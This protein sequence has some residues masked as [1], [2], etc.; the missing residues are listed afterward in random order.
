MSSIIANLFGPIFVKDMAELSRH[1]RT[2]LYRCL[3]GTL[4]LVSLGVVYQ[5]FHRY[6]HQRPGEVFPLA[7]MAEQFFHTYLW[8]QYVAVLLL[9]PLLVPGAVAGEHEKGTLDLLLTTQLRN[10]D[11]YFGKL[12][13][14]V[15][16]L[17][18][19]ILSGIP[20]VAFTILFGGVDLQVFWNAMLGTLVALVWV[21]AN[22]MFC[23]IVAKDALTALVLSFGM[24]SWVWGIPLIIMLTTS[25]LLYCQPSDPAGGGM[26]RTLYY[27]H[28]ELVI[29]SLSPF[30]PFVVGISADLGNKFQRL[31]GN[32][33]LYWMMISPLAWSA[34]VLAASLRVLRHDRTIIK[35]K[36]PGSLAVAKRNLLEQVWSGLWFV[37]VFR[38]LMRWLGT[39]PPDR[40]LWF[41]ITNPL[42][43]RSRRVLVHDRMGGVIIMQLQCWILSIAVFVA[44]FIF[45]VG[46]FKPQEYAW[47][48]DISIWGLLFFISI[49]L[50][51]IGNVL[52]RYRGLLDQLLVTP[53][54]PGELVKGALLTSWQHW[55]LT[56]LLLIVVVVL[57]VAMGY[58]LIWEAI[59]MVVIGFLSLAV[60][61]LEAVAC[62]L[63]AR[64]VVSGLLSGFA[65]P[66]TLWV[67]LPMLIR[68]W[69]VNFW[70]ILLVLGA[71]LP[72]SWALMRWRKNSFTIPFYLGS[73]HLVFVLFASVLMLLRFDGVPFS[74][75]SMIEGGRLFTY[76]IFQ[77]H[78]HL[79][80]ESWSD[81]I[82]TAGY[83][84]LTQLLFLVW[85][86]RW[87]NRNV[88][89][90]VGRM[91]SNSPVKLERSRANVAKHW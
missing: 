17:V 91:P 75:W 41:E 89:V 13:S 6:Q 29:S 2:Y 32:S 37:P 86:H 23:S 71:A 25:V 38:F 53:I 7:L 48:T 39:A 54:S 62:S 88:D 40:W 9:V 61:L 83:Y 72:A 64:S 81:W 15:M 85:L 43:Q 30:A 51:S 8:V 76:A 24:L 47:M 60:F 50:T 34:L 74:E 22:T 11:I 1:W 49:F 67:V 80:D 20:I 69:Q 45:Q 5:D 77:E 35:K 82:H 18:M 33:Y 70:A 3:F 56:C 28:A 12:G 46:S 58:Y 44:L 10:R 90:M 65:I 55:Y 52:D 59:L 63:V 19:L 16:S 31:L 42:W 21:C 26:M 87:L 36:V 73:V 78:R 4:L 68:N 66:V 14:R 27:E 57:F 79:A 84:C